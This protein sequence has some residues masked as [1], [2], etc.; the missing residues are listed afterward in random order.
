MAALIGAAGL[1]DAELVE[2]GLELDARAEGFDRQRRVGFG[3]P[4][5][6]KTDLRNTIQLAEQIRGAFGDVVVFGSGSLALGIRALADALAQAADPEDASPTVRL[7]VIDGFDTD[8]FVD[9]LARLDLPRTLFAVMGGR[10]DTLATMSHFVIVRDRLLRELGA[11]TYQRHI[12]IATDPNDGPLRQIVNDEG[13]CDLPLALGSEDGFT[14]LTAAALFPLACV[15]HDVAAIVAGAADMTERC[16]VRG[17]DG[18]PARLLATALLRGS[19]PSLQ[20]VAASARARTLAYWLERRC[21]GLAA[22]P[23]AT[24]PALTIVLAVTPTEDD[25]T[26]PAAYQDLENVGYLRGQSLAALGEHARTAVE[27]AYWSAG[28]PTL[29]LTCPDLGPHVLGQLVQLVESACALARGVDAPS[30]TVAATAARLT[31]ALAGRPGSE[32]ERA[33]VQRL[34]T[35]REARY[36]V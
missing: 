24:H 20:V 31:F 35:K 4:P 16:R 12:V 19:T 15:G 11:V 22:D 10:D 13:F 8:A 34:A 1:E 17:E 2:I 18:N 27:M 29:T 25:L 26:I 32:A 33:V 6:G 5:I 36:V 7:H 23:S 3:A 9:L 30:S 21:A 28:Q 14:P